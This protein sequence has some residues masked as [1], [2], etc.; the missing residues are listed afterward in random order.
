MCC[1]HV[2]VHVHMRVRAGR[3][4]SQVNRLTH[5][6]VDAELTEPFVIYSDDSAEPF[7]EYEDDSG[8][9]EA[10]E[11]FVTY[12]DAS[13]GAGD[14]RPGAAFAP[15]WLLSRW[16]RVAVRGE[17][18]AATWLLSRWKSVAVRET[19]RGGGLGWAGWVA[20]MARRLTRR[21]VPKSASLTRQLDPTSMFA[22]LTSLAVGWACEWYVCVCVCW[23]V[24]V[25]GGV[26]VC[27]VMCVCGHVCV[28][29]ACVCVCVCVCVFVCGGS[30]WIRRACSPT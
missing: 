17:A 9:A 14:P 12:A 24:W 11:P 19:A 7:V 16:K 25:W 29:C 20:A 30:S 1:P 13:V 26:C 5:R 18:L 28:C 15:P 3:Y 8:A 27:S 21:A 2:S 10:V 22:D 6:M 23:C 4:I